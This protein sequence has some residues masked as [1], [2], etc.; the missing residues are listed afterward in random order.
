M[1]IFVVACLWFWLNIMFCFL[2]AF[3]LLVSRTCVSSAWNWFWF[4]LLVRTVGRAC[5]TRFR[6]CLWTALVTCWT[7]WRTFACSMSLMSAGFSQEFRHWWDHQGSYAS[8]SRSYQHFWYSSCHVGLSR[9]QS[10]R[11]P[12]C[13]YDSSFVCP[14]AFFACL[15]GLV[16]WFVA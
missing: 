11:G 10:W 16:G 6:H 3:C 7:P 2:S 1:L 9:S 8:S 4:Y 13:L 5:K 15:P 14:P 12:P